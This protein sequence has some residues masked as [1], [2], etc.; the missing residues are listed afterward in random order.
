MD[1]GATIARVLT[2]RRASGET[3]IVFRG[4]RFSWDFV[5]RVG[6]R[7]AEVAAPAG[8]PGTA[9]VGLIARNRPAVVAATVAC[10]QAG[11]CFVMVYSAQ[12]PE[13]IAA[14]I[15]SLR[16]PVVAAD[17][18][19]WTDSLRAAV[20]ETGGIGIVL[21][22]DEAEPVRVAEGL[23]RLGPGPHK[24]SDPSVAAEL[25]SSGTTGAPKRIPLKRRTLAL[26]A[27]DSAAT[28]STGT[29]G[30]R[31]AIVI[32]PLGN[33]AGITYITP[34]ATQGQPIE[35]MEKFRLEDWLDAVRRLRPARGA[36]PPAALRMILERN[37]PR[38]DLASLVAIGT[39]GG[40][41]EPEVEDEFERRYGIPLLQGY[42][43]TEYC[44]VIAN[45]TPDLYKARRLE[46]RG[47]VG[48]PRPGVELRIVDPETR[49][50]LPAG[51]VGLLEAKV[52]R[53]G[54]DWIRTTDLGSVDEEGFLWLHG[55]S[56]QAI[57][58]GG[59]K[60]LPETVAA[61]LREHP[62]VADAAVVG[63]P[64]ARLGQVPVAA[65]ELKPGRKVSGDELVAFAK[66]QLVAYQV[67]ARI[68]ILA[69]LPRT[70]SMK[71]DLGALGAQM[72]KH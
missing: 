54:P 50:P 31:P 38:D 20:A 43:A 1:L 6:E 34:F 64:D 72:S 41:I 67:P 23:G 29:A 30:I 70:E 40:P 45:W 60:V 3:A 9:P 11:R 19:D 13:R 7:L 71:I 57:N 47:S 46:K 44:G 51:R 42:G 39:G 32:H 52:D 58:R 17:E 35:L 12:S 24:R 18:D 69:A 5:A 25:L 61:A 62:D 49:E 63:V 68:A 15:R 4:Q 65:V 26:A 21:R 48:K 59:F 16:L 22:G 28:Y 8:A 55:R 56:D 2:E 36:L 14:E 66:Q 53:V 37:I 33:I 27:A 10:M